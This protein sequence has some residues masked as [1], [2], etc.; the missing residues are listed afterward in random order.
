MMKNKKLFDFSEKSR[1]YDILKEAHAMKITRKTT[2]S[3]E[4]Q[5]ILDALQKA[6]S[7]A[8]E[9][10]RRLGQYAAFWRDGKPVKI[11]VKKADID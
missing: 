3:A 1:E 2:P 8:L 9:K 10:K 6:V 11:R 7:Q 4:A 5:A